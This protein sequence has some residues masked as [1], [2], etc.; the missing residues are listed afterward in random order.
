MLLHENLKKFRE[1]KGMSCDMVA[2]LSGVNYST[3]TKIDSGEIR[4]PRV[5]TVYMIAKAL[6]VTIEDLIG[7]E[8]L[9]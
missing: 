9:S 2:R 3:Y 4:S 6:G 7:E 1:E 5:H 8:S